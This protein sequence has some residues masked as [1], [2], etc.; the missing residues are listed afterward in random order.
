MS[1]DNNDFISLIDTALEDNAIS[2][3]MIEKRLAFSAEFSLKNTIKKIE[4]IIR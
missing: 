2:K 1:Q 4:E 3:T